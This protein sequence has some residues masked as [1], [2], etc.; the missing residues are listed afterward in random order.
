MNTYSIDTIERIK[1]WCNTLPREILGYLT[2]GEAF[3]LEVK[4]LTA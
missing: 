4:A 2:Q 1:N 3:A